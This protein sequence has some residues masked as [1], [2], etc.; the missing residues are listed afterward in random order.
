MILMKKIN[1]I[2]LIFLSITV[3]SQNREPLAT[4]DEERNI[5]QIGFNESEIILNEKVAYK[6]ERLNNEFKI[7]SLEDKVLITGEIKNIGYKQ[8]ETTLIFVEQNVKFYNPKII[9]RNDLVF[10]LADLNVFNKDLTINQSKLLDFIKRFN[11]I[12]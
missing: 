5:I 7:L 2:V 9:G 11:S 8:F 6:Y 10:A 12:K 1:F 3:Y 4:I